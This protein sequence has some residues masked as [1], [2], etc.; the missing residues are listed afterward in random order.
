MPPLTVARLGTKLEVNPRRIHLGEGLR[1]AG[2]DIRAVGGA[3]A[4]DQD[5]TFDQNIGQ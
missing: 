4:S 2:E 3:A 1:D 5:L